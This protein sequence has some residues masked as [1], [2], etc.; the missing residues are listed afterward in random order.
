MRTPDARA[1][2]VQQPQSWAKQELQHKPIILVTDAPEF[3]RAFI[4]KQA[5][6]GHPRAISRNG[7]ILLVSDIPLAQ[8]VGRP[9]L[10]SFRAWRRSILANEPAC[11]W[12]VLLRMSAQA[13]GHHAPDHPAADCSVEDQPRRSAQINLGLGGIRWLTVSIAGGRRRCVAPAHLD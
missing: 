3:G 8:A 6:R 13:V 12:G 5:L 10:L 1:A 9:V 11:V 2:K 7:R 4:V